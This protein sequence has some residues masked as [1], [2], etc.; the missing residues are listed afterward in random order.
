LWD[1]RRRLITLAA[2]LAE[3]AG[4]WRRTRRLGGWLVV[5][6]RR[7]HL[8]TTLWIPGASLKSIRVGVWR[9]QHCPVGKHW[10]WVTPVGEATLTEDQRRSAS[11][12]RDIAIP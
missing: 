7:G 11:K 12:H 9:F 3:V 5:R 8:F 10:S 6:C 2:A 1:R 4:A